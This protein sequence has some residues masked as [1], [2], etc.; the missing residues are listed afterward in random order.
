MR[1]SQ[2]ENVPTHLSM[3]RLTKSFRIQFQTFSANM[4]L[5][6]LSNQLL[7]SYERAV[8][9][10]TDLT[11]WKLILS[12]TRSVWPGLALMLT[13]KLNASYRRQERQVNQFEIWR[14]VYRT[15]VLFRSECGL[16][17]SLQDRSARSQFGASKLST[18]AKLLPVSSNA[19]HSKLW[20]DLL[21][22]EPRDIIANKWNM[23][24]HPI[25][26]TSQ[27]RVIKDELQ[28]SQTKI[29]SDSQAQVFP[30]RNSL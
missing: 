24:E 22:G 18:R 23:T 11:S 12:E 20:A 7:G 13:C 8:C 14:F 25:A 6:Q 27:L 3:N 28:I 21:S 19:G 4:S 2:Y 30:T 10:W 16:G 26:A 1:L 17:L 15:S 29:R 5:Q 9:M